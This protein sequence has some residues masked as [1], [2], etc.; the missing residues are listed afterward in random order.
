M[1]SLPATSDSLG[2]TGIYQQIVHIEGKSLFNDVYQLGDVL[3]SKL[4]APIQQDAATLNHTL[5]N[6]GQNDECSITRQ[7]QIDLA[8]VI[9]EQWMTEVFINQIRSLNYNAKAQ[10]TKALNVVAQT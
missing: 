5:S 4:Q 8:R 6:H 10:F 9:L 7:I 3:A 2:S 1:K